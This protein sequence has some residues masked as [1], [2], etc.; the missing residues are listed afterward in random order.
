LF[1]N[2]Q[3]PTIDDA[4][5]ALAAADQL[6]AVAPVVSL[7]AK[8]FGGL[9][10]SRIALSPDGRRLAVSFARPAE[11]KQGA[12]DKEAQAWRD[13]DMQ[14]RKVLV[15]PVDGPADRVWID[16]TLQPLRE[17][18]FSRNG[19]LFAA[20]GGALQPQAG[21]G[22]D[23]IRLWTAEGSRYGP[24]KHSPLRLSSFTNKVFE[25]AF[26]ADARG[27]VLL[28][29]GGDSGAIDRWDAASGRL[30]GTL[31]ADSWPIYHIAVSRSGSLVAAAD[32][33]NVVRLWD[34]TSWTPMQLTPPADRS[35]VP[36]FLA[37]GGNDNWLASGAGTLQLWDLDIDVDSLR[38][39]A[40]RLLRE[41]GQHGAD[42]PTPLWLRDGLCA[43]K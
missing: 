42:S 8:D 18:A 17:I 23:E 1:L 19:T 27:N 37:F 10:P 28:L 12:E 6:A 35:E 14:S 20:G 7:A 29:A 26:A 2:Q 15:V 36:G 11:L 39:K 30:L 3:T 16:T 31:R 41:P 32:S 43:P 4:K 9:V 22:L 21:A 13:L 5:R 40:C 38:R 33:Q 34:T 24:A 25:L